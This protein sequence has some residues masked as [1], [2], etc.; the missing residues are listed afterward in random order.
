MSLVTT[1]QTVKLIH[2]DC[3]EIKTADIKEVSFFFNRMW[4]DTTA[5]VCPAFLCAFQ[6]L[7]TLL[8][9]PYSLHRLKIHIIDF[10]IHHYPTVVISAPN[11]VLVILSRPKGQIQTLYC[12]FLQYSLGI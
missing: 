3:F 10:A 7:I 5:S 6:T 4:L 9:L 2:V 12:C 11:E 8:S 1:T